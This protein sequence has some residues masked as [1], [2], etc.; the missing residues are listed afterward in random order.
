MSHDTNDTVIGNKS[1]ISNKSGNR[2][3]HEIAQVH[4]SRRTVL[5]GGF[6]AASTTF[7]AGANSAW[8]FVERHERLIDFE[9]VAVADG[10]G[11]MPAISPDYEYQVLI[12]WGTPL[13]PGGPEFSYPPN[14]DD[15]A[16]Q[17]GIGHDGMAYF[18]LGNSD[19][20]SAGEHGSNHGMLAINHE[21]GTNSH[22]LG[23]DAPESLDDVRAS[24]HAHGVSVVE[25]EKI[26][27][28]WQTVESDS[29][30]AAFTA[31][32]PWRSAARW[33][34]ARS[35]L[36]TAA[37]NVP[38]GTLNNCANGQTP[39]G[40]Y[41]TCEENFNGYFGANDAWRPRRIATALWLHRQRLR[42]WLA[43]VRP[44]F[45]LSDADYRQ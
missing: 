20:K 13:E 23:K 3:F 29:G 39:W 17:I 27:R 9:P 36:Q 7:F 21:F 16:Q 15:Q 2:P 22:V 25:I 37:G 14:A 42:L 44:R 10:S 34:E 4:L 8:A 1:R 19:G 35:L 33:P 6:A 40:T 18:P 45:D 11:P 30:R 12:P 5:A 38:P 28:R 26:E 31:I 43:P 24:Q 41:L 32:R